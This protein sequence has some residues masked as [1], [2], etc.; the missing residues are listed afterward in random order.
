M[1]SLAKKIVQDTM[2]DPNNIIPFPAQ[3]IYMKTTSPIS[4]DIQNTL[5]I[6]EMNKPISKYDEKHHGIPNDSMKDIDWKANRMALSTAHELSY[7]KTFHHFR[8]TMTIIKKWKKSDSDLCP[9]CSTQPE[10]I[11]HFM[12]CNHQDIQS[13]RSSLIERFFR[14][15]NTLNIETFFPLQEIVRRTTYQQIVY[16]PYQSTKK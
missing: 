10:T 16:I 13:A 1:G 15:L 11:H 3:R 9:M 12:S 2:H 7:R 14:Q 4:H 5:I 6:N 8:N